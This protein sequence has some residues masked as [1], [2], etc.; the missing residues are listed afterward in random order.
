MA[1][2]SPDTVAFWLIQDAS[3]PSFRPLLDVTIEV[4]GSRIQ[5]KSA[6]ESADLAEKLLS[7]VAE[8][9]GR[10][11]LESVD[12]G[13]EPG[14]DLSAEDST[15]YFKARQ[16]EAISFKERLL[17]LSPAQFEG[18]CAA[19]LGKLGGESRVIGKSGDG[20]LDFIA[21]NISLCGSQGPAPIG[22]R[23]LVLGQAKRY[24]KDS[25]IVETDLRAFV[26]AAIRR[27]SDPLDLLTYRGAIMAPL[28]LAFWTTSDF[29][30]SAKRY[31]KAVGLWHL[32]G[33]GL[34]QLA[35]RLG[36]D[37]GSRTESAS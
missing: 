14:Y 28:S 34:A 25:L 4:I 5:T 32:N 33:V 36:V 8:S 20:G 30:P 6:D 13:V 10:L 17:T 18:F 3:N 31:A 16:T 23:T 22:A 21:R 26:G 27:S 29:Q 24:S 11:A 7:R 15:L 12:D 37:A 1:D 2:P 9:L 19:L 35:I